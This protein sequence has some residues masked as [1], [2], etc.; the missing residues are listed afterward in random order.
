M[1]A[2]RQMV[3]LDSRVDSILDSPGFREA[4]RREAGFAL[5]PDRKGIA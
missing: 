4:T 1:I 3:K 2:R 5:D